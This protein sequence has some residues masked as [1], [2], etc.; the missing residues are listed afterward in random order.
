MG[1]PLDRFADLGCGELQEDRD[2]LGEEY[3]PDLQEVQ[4]DSE[5]TADESSWQLSQG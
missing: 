3:L 4:F 1:Y 5:W 2:Q